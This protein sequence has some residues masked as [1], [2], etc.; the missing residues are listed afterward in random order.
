MSDLLEAWGDPMMRHA[1]TVHFPVVLSI[2]GIPFAIAAAVASRQ[3]AL[4]WTVLAVYV[5]LT[6]SAFVARNTGKDA[7]HVVEGS[8]DEAGHDELEAHEEHGENLWLLPA[9]MCAL[10]GVSFAGN[11]KVRLA[12][13]WLAV[14]GGVLVA[15]RVAHTAHHGGRLVYVH[16]AGR[17]ADLWVLLAARGTEADDENPPADPRLAHFRSNVRPILAGT[18]MRCHNPRR[19]KRSGRL[20]QTTIA[21]LLAGGASGPAIVPGRPQ[22]SLLIAAVRGTDPDLVMPPSEDER[23]SADE[24]A[25]LER[26]IAEGAV[27]EPFEISA[28]GPDAPE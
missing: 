21:G 20:D 3:A 22:E 2:I 23:L 25:A 19:L 11:R 14:A 27:W 24:I 4:R 9:G 1:M 6:V 10:V 5:V 7:E 26:W 16:N 17:E 12:A 18:C 13:S 28:G 8:L 15:E